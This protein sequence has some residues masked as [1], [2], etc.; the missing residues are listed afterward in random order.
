[1]FDDIRQ[2]KYTARHDT[3]GLPAVLA[4]PCGKEHKIHYK[5]RLRSGPWYCSCGFNIGPDLVDKHDI[6]NEKREYN[7]KEARLR[8]K[9]DA[10]R[11]V[12]LEGHPKA[13]KAYDYAWERG[14][15]SGLYSV[16]EELQEIAELII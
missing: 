1:M 3:L 8:F 13:E 10:I 6:N 15:S 11:F 12:G 2:G 5:I 14:H 4:C 9:E 16:L 7:N